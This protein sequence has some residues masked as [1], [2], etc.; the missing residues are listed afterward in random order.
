MNTGSMKMK[1]RK[2]SK[3]ASNVF[4]YNVE[5]AESRTASP[6]NG[7]LSSLELISETCVSD[8]RLRWTS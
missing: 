6:L 4:F 3:Q 8:P 7:R 1:V 2:Y 5:A